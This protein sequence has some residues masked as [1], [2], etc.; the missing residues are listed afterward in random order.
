MWLALGLVGFVLWLAVLFFLGV[1]TLLKGR[2]VLF[3]LG[4]FLPVLWAF[5]ALLPAR[6]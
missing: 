1:P 2:Y 4:I 5:G 3:V 6:N